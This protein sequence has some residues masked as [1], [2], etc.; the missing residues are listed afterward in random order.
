MNE[1]FGSELRR[2]ASPKFARQRRRQILLAGLLG[3]LIGLVALIDG[4]DA[5]RT[6]RIVR[7]GAGGVGTELT[8]WQVVL[9]GAFVVFVSGFVLWK[10][11][12]ARGGR[13]RGEW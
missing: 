7:G 3:V 8:G 9:L 12:V 11:R 6:G 1:E 10:Q 2:L 13:S 5:M 4:I